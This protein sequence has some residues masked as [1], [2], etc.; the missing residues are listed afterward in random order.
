MS[1]HKLPEG[2]RFIRALTQ[3]GE[4][5]GYHVEKEFPVRPP[6]ASSPPA[7]DVAWFSDTN[8]KFPLMIFEIESAATNTMANNAMKV[9]AQSTDAFEKPLF[10]FHLILANDP[11]SYRI[12]DL[13][14]QYGNHNYRAYVLGKDGG[15]RLA[16]DI[17]A[18]HRRIR[19][20]VHYGNL[21]CVLSNGDWNGLVNPALVLQ[22]AARLELS[23]DIRLLHYVWLTLEYPDLI[24]EL[25]LVL[26]DEC[27]KGWPSLPELD[28]YVGTELGALPLCCL[29]IRTSSNEA[30]AAKWLG[31]FY[32]F[33]SSCDAPV[34]T[35]FLGESP[36]WNDFLIW[37]LPA[38]VV[39]CSA[40][41]GERGTFR[42][43]MCSKLL[44]ILEQLEP[45]PVD[46]LGSIEL[47]GLQMAAWICHLS[48]RF[49][50]PS[51]YKIAQSYINQHGGIDKRLLFSLSHTS[52][53]DEKD[54]QHRKNIISCPEI[55]R[56]RAYV[57]SN[58]NL[59]A[60]NPCQLALHAV[61]SE[62]FMGEWSEPIISTLWGDV[63]GVPPE[64][65]NR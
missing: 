59:S 3:L 18:Q 52:L 60:A 54:Y 29:M 64:N 47:E 25:R 30:E 1:L 15:S 23:M 42:N 51:Q 4:V 34:H 27:E 43:E 32:D 46:S 48:A 44:D 17:L 2:Q 6:Q 28:N 57:L 12:D 26:T 31:H 14:S 8:Q 58:T 45:D 35:T 41:A 24:N 9:L 65:A 5:L 33:L 53:D 7:V 22:E 37:I 21:Y 56:F 50:M 55:D 40:I 13:R 63:A 38:F 19:T 36:D 16:L 49:E 11:K 62:S 61:S 10:F 20:E 39:L